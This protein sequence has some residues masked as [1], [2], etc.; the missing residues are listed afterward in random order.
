MLRIRVIAANTISCEFIYYLFAAEK[1]ISAAAAAA[2]AKCVSN[3]SHCSQ[4]WRQMAF[5]RIT[6]AA[7]HSTRFT[8]L[9]TFWQIVFD[10]TRSLTG[11]R[12][13]GRWL[14]SWW[15]SFAFHFL[16]ICNGK[17]M[18]MAHATPHRRPTL[19]R[20]TLPTHQTTNDRQRR[21]VFVVARVG[22]TFGICYQFCV[23]MREKMRFDWLK[24][25]RGTR[26]PISC[27]ASCSNHA[28]HNEIRKR[29]NAKCARAHKYPSPHRRI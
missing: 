12:K 27:N 2:T 14:G 5:T 10:Y 1:W 17:F 21:L 26:Q 24:G 22:E 15:I 13:S 8:N 16:N 6:L 9:C 19:A 18:Q 7:T 25:R 23:R 28:R 4:L 11:I 3:S 29:Q 20:E